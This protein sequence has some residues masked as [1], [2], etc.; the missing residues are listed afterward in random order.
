[1][2]MSLDVLGFLVYTVSVECLGAS[3]RMT[4][5]VIEYDALLQGAR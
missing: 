5:H 2:R 4:N 3:L 1:M